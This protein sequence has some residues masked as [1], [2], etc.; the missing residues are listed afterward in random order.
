MTFIGIDVQL[1]RGLAVAVMDDRARVIRTT[2]FGS[3]Q[4][5]TTASDL[6]Q[7]YPGAT[8]GIDAP[9]QPLRQPRQRYWTRSGWRSARPGDR[10]H[11]RHCE[12]AVAALGLA[13]PQWT[14]L[15]D[16]APAWMAEGF[17]LFEALEK[18]GLTTEEVFPSAAYRQLDQDPSA[19]LTMP[20]SSF[21]NG[22]KDM[23]DA[24]VAAFSVREF[25]QGRG[26][27]VGG[28]DGLGRIVLPRPL[29]PDC[30]AQGVLAWPDP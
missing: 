9:R 30:R 10:G 24:V 25:V 16:A 20:L 7:R 4:P 26:C 29:E 22:P 6:A 27:A 18:R 17:A 8:V 15:H 5:N 14:P 19:T 3:G 23:L 11:G 1:E 13:R 2:W 21:A 12:V 28:G